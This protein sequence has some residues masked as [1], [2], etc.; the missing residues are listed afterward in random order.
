MTATLAAPST[1]AAPARPGRPLLPLLAL[2]A[3]VDL[4]VLAASVGPL[5]GVALL[6]V[7]VVLPGW[8]LVR[9]LGYTPVNAAARAVVTVAA[10]LAVLLVVGLLVDVA[11]LAVHLRL[12]TWPLVAGLDLALL[13]LGW[14]RPPGRADLPAPPEWRTVGTILAG[15]ALPALA[16]AG[17]RLLDGGGSPGLALAAAVA[18]VAALLA[19]VLGAPRLTDAA[20]V[21]L[22][23]CVAAALILSFS[24]RGN[25]LVGYDVQQEFS[26]FAHMRAA[27]VWR[28][29]STGSADD[30]YRAM[31]SITVLPQLFAE[32]CHLAPLTVFRVV[33]PLALLLVPATAFGLARA[34]AS[35]RVAAAVATLPLLL[36]AYVSQLP[37]VT[38]QAVALAV[39][40]ALL[41]VLFDGTGG[42]RRTVL[43]CVLGTGMVLSHYTTSYLAVGILGAT[44][45]LVTLRRRRL[46]GPRAVPTA[47]VAWLLGFCVLWNVGVTGS[48]TNVRDAATNGASSA[49]GGAVGKNWLQA[50]VPSSL[51]PAGYAQR[52]TDEIQARYP[53]MT[54]YPAVQT[55]PY[56]PAD[57]AAIPAGRP[58]PGLS[59]VV[60]VATPVVNELAILAIV[61]AVGLALWGVRRRRD[62]AI[63]LPLAALVTLAVTAVG[64]VSG[65]AIA[66][67]NADRLY[68]QSMMLFAV[69]L[70][71]LAARLPRSRT[72][73]VAAALVMA[74][75]AT[76]T[77]VYL[78]GKA[79]GINLAGTGEAAERY[80]YSDTDVATARWLA[81]HTPAGALIFA[82]RYGELPLW[83]GAG[84]DRSVFT[85]L[86]PTAVDTRG[87][88]YLTHVNVVDARARGAVG[89]TITT[90]RTPLDF[91]DATKDLIYS[92]GTTRVYR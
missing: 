90:Y 79:P 82:D 7:L 59:T 72:I 25:Y 32:L 77:S 38:R 45:L 14:N 41:L 10:S 43:L 84:L 73:Y 67:Y 54:H 87:Y 34:H 89:T 78:T 70:A 50:T 5:P 69:P 33:L 39:F 12:S 86:A 6:A 62:L 31:L 19:V 58:V 8:L 15:L 17:A 71:A 40:G 20:A 85:T 48:A 37:A 2:I 13:G 52:A 60:S 27:G 36:P 26:A 88:V 23:S 83:Q 9:R 44:W 35:R 53:W 18:A 42:R 92:T 4:L 1:A 68:L 46:T 16:W 80:L 76:Q 21:Y 91:Y 28:P 22:L 30:A 61:A 75:N 51:T 74:L 24:T 64:R 3:A 63:E 55:D 11:C 29:V 81:G 49:G 56:P 57:P 65:T 66:S 47:A